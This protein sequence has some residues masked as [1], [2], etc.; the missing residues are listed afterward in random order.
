MS[1]D[2]SATVPA[3]VPHLPLSASVFDGLDWDE[4]LVSARLLVELPFRLLCEDARFDIVVGD[5][6]IAFDVRGHLVATSAGGTTVSVD[7]LRSPAANRSWDHLRAS[8]FAVE[9]R[10]MRTA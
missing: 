9:V 1:E 6:S 7:D 4:P 3:D 2:G 8:P 5:C 10:A